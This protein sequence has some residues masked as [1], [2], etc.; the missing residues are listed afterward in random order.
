MN[1]SARMCVEQVTSSGYPQKSCE[2]VRLRPVFSNDK[3]SPNYSFSQ[4][5]P[6]GVLE[7]TITNTAAWGAFEIG[8][9]Y[10]IVIS[11]RA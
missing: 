3:E 5:T 1:I 10:D 8:R 11:P 2:Q 7:L 4:A 6:S 9:E